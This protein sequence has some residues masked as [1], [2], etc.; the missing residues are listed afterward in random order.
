MMCWRAKRKVADKKRVDNG[1]ALRLKP[2]E[3]LKAAEKLNSMLVT[4][5]G[6]T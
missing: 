5:G 1:H 4:G 3:R 2:D 6:K